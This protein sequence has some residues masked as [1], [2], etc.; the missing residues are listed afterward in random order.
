MNAVSPLVGV[1]MR[2]RGPAPQFA[3]GVLATHLQNDGSA[4]PRPS[5]VGG[6]PLTGALAVTAYQRTAATDAL[7]VVGRIDEHA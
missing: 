6:A 7:R 2:P 1:P 3:T 5:R 4:A